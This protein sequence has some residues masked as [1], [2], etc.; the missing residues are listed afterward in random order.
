LALC[1]SAGF[2]QSEFL[3]LLFGMVLPYPIPAAYQ[4]IPAHA[5]CT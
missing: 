3:S 5:N 4:H 1:C 2:G